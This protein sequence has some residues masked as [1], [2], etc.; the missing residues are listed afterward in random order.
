MRWFAANNMRFALGIASM[1]MLAACKS[2]GPDYHVPANSIY[3]EQQNKSARFDAQGAKDVVISQAPLPGDWWSLYD[4][5]QLNSLVEQALQANALLK[6]AA[7]RLQVAQA[8]YAVAKA[9]GGWSLGADAGV[10]RGQISAQT[11]LL[12]EALPPF[13][14]ADAS[15]S[16]SYQFDFWGKLKRG[17][18][19]AQA[20]SEAFEAANDLARIAVAA[21]VVGAYLEICH[22]NHEIKV[23]QR[24]L[25]L[26]QNSRDI[27]LR[28]KQAGRGTPT[29]V[30]RANSQVG[31][32]QSTI[33][34]LRARRQAAGYELADLLG[35]PPDRIPQAVMQCEEAP[36]LAH[37]IP[38]GDGA[39]LL[40]RRPDVRQA[41]RELAAATA[42]IGFA[43]ADLYPNVRLGANF[44]YTGLARDIGKD[45]TR[46][47][48]VG[49][50]I[51]WEMPGPR[52]HARVA[53]AEAGAGV[54]LAEFDKT[55]LDALR[56]VQTIL[57]RYA[58]DLRRLEA[59]A[60]VRDHA[61]A[62]ADN[63]RAL[64]QAGRQAYL[65]SLDADRV[66]SG[67]EASLAEAQAQV[68]QDQVR[69]F[70][71]LGG[72]WRKGETIGGGPDTPRPE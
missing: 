27:A 52:A 16:A 5:A 70:L 15:V 10:A 25:E 29:A 45:V 62:A 18:E 58:E 43:T 66:L 11:L 7:A 41:E 59:L 63:E 39:A 61:K 20:S 14:F 22:G 51:S 36:E 23:A 53:V 30:D 26:Q 21:G 31:L 72:G 33:P 50:L 3:A 37:P 67:S 4:D 28:L 46:A 24:S 60:R 1:A 65:F 35:L 56:D 9:A 49:P 48:S 47:W 17:T 6:V 40:R 13:N 42:E 34:S 57:N 68:S 12:T 32:L 54:A 55:V 38:V 19:A 44:G 8:H 2:V 64:Y 69:L 71:A